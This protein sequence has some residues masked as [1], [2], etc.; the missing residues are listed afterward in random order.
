MK[1][2]EKVDSKVDK[3]RKIHLERN[4]ITEDT[5]INESKCKSKKKKNN[6]NNNKKVIY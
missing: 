5:E 4:K 6:N 3:I 1:R 2:K